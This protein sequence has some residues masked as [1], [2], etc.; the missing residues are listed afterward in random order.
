MDA[1]IKFWRRRYLNF[2]KNY[3][4]I[5]KRAPQYMIASY[6]GISRE[7]LSKIRNQQ[8]LERQ[9]LVGA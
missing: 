2:Q 4:H 7:F 1:S 3:P 6:L 5:E 8:G 9:A